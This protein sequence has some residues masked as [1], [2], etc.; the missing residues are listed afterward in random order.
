MLYA[1]AVPYVIGQAT[2][3]NI[4]IGDMTN[5]GF[6]LLMI[7]KGQAIGGDF[8]YNITANVSHYKNE[9]VK[10]SDN[11]DEVIFGG[12][13][14]EMI[15]TRAQIGTAFPEFYGYIVDGIFDSQTEADNHPT[16]FGEDGTYNEPGHFKFRDINGRDP[17]GNLTGEPDGTIDSDD[18]DYI[19]SPHPD[20][21]A[22]L[23]F[24]LGYKNFDLTA[25]FYTSYGNDMINYVRR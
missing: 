11:V 21:T 15:Y 2:N 7:Y 6:D 17:E 14:R 5:N 8:R 10:I 4:N 23:T 20:F 12:G 22:G 3:P 18:R 1:V 9:I 13:F 19:G 25:F 24:D 16:A